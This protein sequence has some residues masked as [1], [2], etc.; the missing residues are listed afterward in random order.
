M[1]DSNEM[2][3]IECM[4]AELDLQFGFL[5]MQCC[6]LIVVLLESRSMIQRQ[7]PTAYERNKDVNLGVDKAHK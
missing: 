6:D 3:D 2:Q 5:M 7:S 1:H 4:Y